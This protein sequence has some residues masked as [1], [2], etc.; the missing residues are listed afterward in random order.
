MSIIKIFIVLVTFVCAL[1]V[2]FLEENTESNGVANC[3]IWQVATLSGYD[4]L[5]GDD[6]HPGSLAE[7]TGT[8]DRFLT[9]IPVVSI[10]SKDWKSSKYHV[11]QIKR[12]NQIHKV[13]SWD[14]C[15]D[16]DCG[17][18][19]TRN[20]KKFGGNFLLDVD[21]RTLI[22]VFGISH[23]D[24]TLE[25]VKFNICELFDAKT[26]CQEIWFTSINI[27]KI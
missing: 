4:N 11:I 25:K 5:G 13:Q 18:C 8:T 1:S 24:Q 17:G 16:R 27:R 3:T 23:W 26:N 9:D 19:C 15:D 7:W 6:R 12:N 14:L 2:D 22:N 10:H 21:K 20:A